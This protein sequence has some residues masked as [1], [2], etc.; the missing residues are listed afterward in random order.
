[1]QDTLTKKIFDVEEVRKDFPILSREVEGKPLVYLDNAATSQKPQSVINAISD[2][3]SNYNAN[4]HRGVY[5]ISIKASEAYE[6]AKIKVKEFINASNEREIIF[7]RGT[8]EA[9]NLI[10]YS[11]GLE[12]VNEGD[13]III[14][15]MEHHANIVPWQVLSE[16]RKAI[17][18]VIPVND[19][20]ELLI[21]EYKKLLSDKTK[22][23][24]IGHISNSLGTI[25]PVKEIIRLAKE[26]SKDIAVVVD[27]AQAIHH[28]KVDVRDMGADFY[29]FSSHK[30]YGPMGIGVLY[31]R[32]ELLEA[33]PPYQTG[34]DMISTVSF[35]GTTYNDIPMK[36]EAGTPNVEGA[37]GLTA[38]I[39]YINAIGFD[40]IHKQEAELLEYATA[41]LKE[42]NGLK[43][44]GTAK[45]KTGVISFVVEGLNALDIGIMLDT[46]GVAVRTGQHCT[47]PLMERFS[48]PGTVRASF[49]FYNSKEEIDVFVNALKKAIEIL[50]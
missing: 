25:N 13:E 15:E 44:I 20:G 11:Y 42:I 9:I 16:K 47:E 32:S 28:T 36:F 18:K 41:Q 21:D 19:S 40:D 5:S 10:A 37:V 45:E 24:A 39:D 26:K 6:N 48:I 3:Y 2:Y 27:G 8:T 29:V 23:V 46:N 7:T 38:A 17:L 30:M 12:N 34:G 22:I 31:G 49:A 4:I 14:S 50:K 43:I 33:M 1:M 35:K